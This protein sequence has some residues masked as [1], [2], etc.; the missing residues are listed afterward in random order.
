MPMT[1]RAFGAG[2][3]RGEQRHDA[4]D[5]REGRHQDRPEPQPGRFERGRH[6]ILA[7]LAQH[8]RELDDQDRVLRRQADQ[9]DQ[10]DL[11][12]DV[13]DVALRVLP[14]RP[15]GRSTRR[16]R[17]T[18]V[19]S[20][21]LN[22]SPQLSYC[23]AS[24]RN[25]QQDGE[26]EHDQRVRRAL[27]LV[28]HVGPVEAHVRRQRLL[29]DLLERRRAPARSCSPRAGTPVSSAERYEVE[30][31][32]ELGPARRPRRH[33]GVER[34]H[35]AV[36]CP[37]TKNSPNCFGSRRY[38]GSACTYTLYTRPNRLKSFT[39]VLPSSAPSVLLTSC[40]RRARPSAPSSDRCP[41]TPAARW[42]GTASRYARSPAAAAPPA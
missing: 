16:R 27:L 15:T 37:R 5:E 22:G 23:A 7:L 30:A 40:E 10:A 11:R 19:P 2:A 20:S 13:V 26:R 18:G 24:T 35:L 25:T 1:L 39:Y 32:G 34:H 38:S 41:R 12:E 36:R 42:R 28:R 6:R 33:Q 3:G 14:R 31:V 21:T 17:R 4:E 9:H 29:R 8:L